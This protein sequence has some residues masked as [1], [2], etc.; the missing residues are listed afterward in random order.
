MYKFHKG[1]HLC[2]GIW[3][4]S[5][6]GGRKWHTIK[7]IQPEYIVKL[8]QVV[9]TNIDMCPLSEE[10]PFH[11]TMPKDGITRA[12]VD[13]AWCILDNDHAFLMDDTCVREEYSEYE[14]EIANEVLQQQMVDERWTNIDMNEHEDDG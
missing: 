13:C 2:Q 3:L 11:C 10:N 9:N 14:V 4:E 5:L 8:E 6:Q 1:D 7:K 12:R